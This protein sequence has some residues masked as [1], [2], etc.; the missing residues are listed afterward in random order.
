[1]LITERNSPHLAN[2]GLLITFNS[3]AC[4]P[5]TVLLSNAGVYGAQRL[6]S[7]EVTR[8]CYLQPINRI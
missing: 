5:E 3:C 1:M 8:S 2:M 4:T 7:S 6:G